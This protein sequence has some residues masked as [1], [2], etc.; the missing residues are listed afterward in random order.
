[1]AEEV[2]WELVDNK[3]PWLVARVNASARAG[4]ILV[5]DAIAKDMKA[6]APRDTGEMADSIDSQSVLAG[7]ESEVVIGVDYWM[8]PNYGTRYQAAQPFVEPAI[9]RHRDD[10]PEHIV[11]EGFGG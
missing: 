11:A 2:T 10:L 1:M 8:Y 5:A 7:F 6:N 9:D 4:V 3:I